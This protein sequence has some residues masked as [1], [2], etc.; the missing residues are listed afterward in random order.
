MDDD[1]AAHEGLWDGGVDAPEWPDWIP[2]ATRTY[3][4]HTEGGRTIRELAAEED[5]HPSTILRRVRRVEC[6]RDD[7]LVDSALRQIAG[8]SPVQRGSTVMDEDKLLREALPT[9][10]RLAE[11]DVL[12][13]VARDLEKA[14]VA[15]STREG[16]PQRLSV[17]D[18]SLAI[19]MAVRDWIACTTPE[20]RIKRYRIT[21]H[22]RMLLRRIAMGASGFAEAQTPFAGYED[23]DGTQR[24]A[25]QP[26]SPLAI[27]ARRRDGT[28]Q[29]FLS[30]ELVA[31]GD[32]LREDL[33]LAE[34]EMSTPRDWEDFLTRLGALAP[35]E[36]PPRP[37]IRDTSPQAR[38]ERALLDLGPGL[39]DVALRTC[40]L[41]E[42]LEQVERRLGWSARSGKVV[43]RIALER[44]HQHYRA[45]EPQGGSHGP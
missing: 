31:A 8:G 5:V 19:E 34:T 35:A 14:V 25:G 37:D 24:R 33:A 2:A 10:R 9:L 11:P 45:C 1:M 7:P 28:G 6:S 21:M 30:R 26:D 38:V 18:R 17:I 4:A 3:F 13:A 39:A 29:L 43:L 27:L 22:G 23:D 44:L 42:G 40:C 32:R 41:Q 20:S 12:L 36:P 16:E 15:R